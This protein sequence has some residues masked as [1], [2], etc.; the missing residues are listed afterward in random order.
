MQR[1]REKR[2]TWSV[3]EVA[4]ALESVRCEKLGR[5]LGLFVVV[6]TTIIGTS[7]FAAFQKSP[8]RTV[9]WIVVVLSVAAAVTA[10]VKEFA[11]YAK[12]SDAHRNAAAKYEEL[13]DTAR[14]LEGLLRPGPAP[15]DA[16]EQ[17]LALE[18]AG[19]TQDNSPPLISPRAWDRA[20]YWMVKYKH[21]RFWS[22]MP[23]TDDIKKVLGRVE[24]D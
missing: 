19:W 15:A 8:D 11:Q 21:K 17:F 1:L 3:K 13:G 4:H 23:E 24:P 10:A 14:R 12:G 20:V 2:A 6:L 16:E 5:V 18:R 7:A 22:G 9:K